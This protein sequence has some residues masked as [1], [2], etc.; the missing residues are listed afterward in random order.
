MYFKIILGATIAF[1][2]AGC[3]HNHETADLSE[4]EEI[5]FQYTTY[6]NEFELFAEADPFVVG[7]TANILSHLS[8][9][10]DFTA[11]EKGSVTLKITVDG[12]TTEQTIDSPVRKGIYSF[13]IQPRVPGRGTL[14]YVIST[15]KGDLKI[16]VPEITV[17]GSLQEAAE[18]AGKTALS[19]T[20]TVVFTKEQ[21]WKIEFSTDKPA[22]E[23]F[24][25][26]IKTT[27]QVRSAQADEIL[28]TA[29][30]T[31]IVS[32]TGSSILEGNGVTNSQGLFTITGSGLADNNSAVRYS[33]AKNNYEKAKADY[34]R[35]TVLAEDKIV[36]EK[37]LLQARNQYE[38]TKS[39]YDNLRENFNASGQSVTSP[40]TGFIKKLFVTNGQYV[41]VGQPLVTVSQN[42]TLVLRAEVQQKW[43]P[44]LETISTAT[45]R[46]TGE[47]KTYSLE[48]LN[49]KV[50]SFGKSATDD[51]YLIPVTLQ[52]SNNGS[53]VPGSFV[54]LYLMTVTNSEALTLP[55][56]AIIEEQGNYFLFVQITPEL[57]EKREIKTGA[58]DGIKTEIV[59]GI[60]ADERVVTKGA[61]LIR[62]A[63]ATGTLDAHSGHVH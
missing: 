57:F 19:K 23:P 12:Q 36:S 22:R 59:Q 46:N 62:L 29:K 63:Q 4:K 37:E 56:S 15:E 42:R 58:T 10:P 60:T 25:H 51:S 32:M 7:D 17:F 31:G 27:A 47:G 26:V 9:L 14:E 6:S 55:N 52:I 21:S 3:N 39:V 11:L 28:V 33:E 48:E 61:I 18:A 35:A 24:G 53:F 40:M 49:G 20:N 30:A 45:I 5:K 43:A 16:T 34:D 2:L 1:I 50:L 13:D 44:Y 41:E 8:N 38:N 54:E